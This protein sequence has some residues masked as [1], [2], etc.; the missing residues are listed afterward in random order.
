MPLFYR[1]SLSMQTDKKKYQT[2]LQCF[3][4]NL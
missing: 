1:E 3:F 2:N 4:F